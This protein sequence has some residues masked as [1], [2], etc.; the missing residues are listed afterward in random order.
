M[1][2]QEALDLAQQLVR[3]TVEASRKYHRALVQGKAPR[4]EDEPDYWPGYRETVR[5]RQRIL[6]HAELDHFPA[7][8]FRQRAPRQTVE[9]FEYLRANYKQT[10]LPVFL[11][12]ENTVGRVWFDANWSATWTAGQEGEGAEQA[13]ADLERY[14]EELDGRGSWEQ[15]AK[16]YLTHETLVDANAVLAW[17]ASE[18]PTTTTV[19]DRGELLE[20]IAGDRLLPVLPHLYRCDQVVARQIG[21]HFL[22]EEDEKSEVTYGGRRLRVGRIFTFL[23]RDVVVR[24]KQVG[25]Y[26][27]DHYEAQLLYRHGWDQVPARVLGGVPVKRGPASFFVSP[28]A[29]A[30][31]LLDLA[32]LNEQYLNAVIAGCVYPHRVMYGD[33]CNFTRNEGG[34]TVACDGGRLFHADGS[35]SECPSCHGSGLRSRLT[36]LGVL[37]VKPATSTQ[38]GDEAL[39]SRPLEFISP[40]TETPEFLRSKIDSD[41]RRAR[42][43]LRL[44]T[45]GDQA[46]GTDAKVA[47]AALLNHKALTAFVKPIGDRL[48]ALLQFGY[49]AAAWQRH[50]EAAPRVTVST[51]KDYD[52]STEADFL[53]QLDA[54]RQAGLP[55]F[56]VQAYLQRFLEALFYDDAT[57]RAAFDTLVQADRLLMVPAAELPTLEAR[58]LAEPWEVVLHQSGPTLLQELVRTAPGYLDQ[59][60]AARIAQLQDLARQRAPLPPAL[61]GSTVED[62]LA[63]LPD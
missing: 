57:A 19:D 10:T 5:Q 59:D 16:D 8:L 44:N 1:T 34:Q 63:D 22:L 61:P 53:S 13:K 49:Q 25:S 58:R 30:V 38:P 56:V 24:I 46:P 43:I 20:V 7:H 50:A 40:S 48:F 47:T 12:F 33:P 26:L 14:L 62:I 15:Y 18:V 6:T 4:P 39:P 45:T 28:F 36:P 3:E 2:D 23:D 35:E 54:A 51:P 29:Y 37:L 11:D 55:P 41:E 9:E 31:D 52:L 17:Y 32:L 42:S 21:R 27:D 60:L